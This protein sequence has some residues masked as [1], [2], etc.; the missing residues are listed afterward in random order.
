MCIRWQW[1]KAFDLLCSRFLISWVWECIGQSETGVEEEDRWRDNIREPP[2]NFLDPFYLA[3]VPYIWYLLSES[4]FLISWVW[5]CIGQSETGVEEE[6]RWDNIREPPWRLTSDFCQ[7][8][9]CVRL[10]LLSLLNNPFL[11][12][13]HIKQLSEVKIFLNDVK[14]EKGKKPDCKHGL[15]FLLFCKTCP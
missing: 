13:S 15:P 6:D 8:G 2:W 12:A 11:L 7:I 4:R 3:P 1:M 5:E 9:M 10:Y 14:L